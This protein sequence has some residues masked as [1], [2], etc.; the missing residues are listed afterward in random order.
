MPLVAGGACQNKYGVCLS[1]R[2]IRGIGRERLA[3]GV[4]GV[5]EEF[6]DGGSTCTAANQPLEE[7]AR[8]G[9]RTVAA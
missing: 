7:S 2:S 3:P 8:P 1:A 9:D 6:S 4:I 5:S